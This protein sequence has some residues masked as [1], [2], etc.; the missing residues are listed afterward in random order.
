MADQ[1]R[2]N[3]SDLDGCLLRKEVHPADIEGL[4]RLYRGAR[5]IEIGAAVA[6][7]RDFFVDVP[8]NPFL[9]EDP[10]WTVGEWQL[11]R[12]VEE[13]VDVVRRRT[14]QKEHGSSHEPTGL[15]KRASRVSSSIAIRNRRIGGRRSVR[16]ADG[17]TCAVNATSAAV[18]RCFEL[19]SRSHHNSTARWIRY[20]RRPSASG[21][22]A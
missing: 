10:D 19:R 17:S 4:P 14:P 13:S 20:R 18:A 22:G 7:D 9:V 21:S 11:L 8:A 15:P 3:R 16:A 5:P 2:N 6:D 12:V 1:N